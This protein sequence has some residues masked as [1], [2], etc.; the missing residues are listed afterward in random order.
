MFNNKH[1]SAYIFIYGMYFFLFLGVLFIIFNQITKN[2]L[3]DTMNAFNISAEDKAE[4]AR[5][6]GLWNLM[7]YILVF[8]IIVFFIVHIGMT[9]G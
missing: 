1:G 4:S 5:F 3:T 6:M 8:L 7:P 2:E 9:G